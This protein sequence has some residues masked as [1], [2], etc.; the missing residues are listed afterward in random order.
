MQ[1]LEIIRCIDDL[2]SWKRLVVERKEVNLD[3]WY[4]YLLYLEYF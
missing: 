2:V 1:Y 4:K 3:L